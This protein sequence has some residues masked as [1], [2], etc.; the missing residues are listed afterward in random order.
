MIIVIYRYDPETDTW[1]NVTPMEKAR[2]G[3]G[4]ATV[5]RFLYAIGG[6]DGDHRLRSV[7][8]YHPERKEW[9][10]VASMRI[11]RSGAGRCNN[12]H[13]NAASKRHI[14]PHAV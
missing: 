8:H 6:Y 13:C 14:Y 9:I 12:Q 5:T 10:R 1:S 11:A 3:V 7:E 2:I 4:V